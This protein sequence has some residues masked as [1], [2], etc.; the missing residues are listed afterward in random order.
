MQLHNH[1]TFRIVEK[2]MGEGQT[3]KN[4]MIVN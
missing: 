4:I 1:H 3:M 2:N